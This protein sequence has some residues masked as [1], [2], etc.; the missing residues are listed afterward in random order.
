MSR[1]IFLTVYKNRTTVKPLNCLLGNCRN[2]YFLKN[3]QYDQ[4]LE[5]YL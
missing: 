4:V 5:A 2:V 3:N 1:L